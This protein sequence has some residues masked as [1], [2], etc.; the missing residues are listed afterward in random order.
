[1][2]GLIRGADEAPVEDAVIRL[3]RTYRLLAPLALAVG[4]VVMLFDGLKLLVTNW[5]LTIVQVLPA[6]WAWLAMTD[7]KAHGLHGA[8]FTILTGPLLVGAFVLITAVTAASFFSTPC[9]LSRSRCLARPIPGTDEHAPWSTAAWCWHG[10]PASVSSWHC[11]PVC[12]NRI[13]PRRLGR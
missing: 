3:S 12:P 1:M 13:L 11:P 4:G 7:L 2:V 8:S 9:L 10:A 5:R 6:I